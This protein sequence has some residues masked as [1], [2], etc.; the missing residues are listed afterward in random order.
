MS[1]QPPGR[2]A[3][4]VDD[5]PRLRAL[6]RQALTGAGIDVEEY[7]SSE[8]FLA[9]YRRRRPGCIIVDIGL[10]GINGLDLLEMIATS[11]G[12]DPAVVLSGNGNV[13][14]AVRAGR[15]GVVDFIEKPFRISDLVAA[16]EKALEKLRAAGAGPAGALAALS[17]RERQVLLAF[18]D[19]PPNKAVA[20]RLGLSVRTVEV[21]RANMVRK[22]GV[23][24]LTQALFLAR[25]GGYL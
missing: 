4:I 15:L 12:T 25:D 18:A 21:Y 14:S 11:G 19:G 22:L 3:Y 9:G 10:P 2:L 24:N 6:V 13:P 5:E 7:A 8:S 16:V 1:S 23:R 17:A 20:Y